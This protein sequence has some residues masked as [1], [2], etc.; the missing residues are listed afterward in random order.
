MYG[1]SAQAPGGMWRRPTTCWPC[2]VRN[3]TEP[4]RESLRPTKGGPFTGI[5]ATLHKNCVMH[6]HHVAN[7][8]FPQPDRLFE[9]AAA[10]NAAVDLFNAH[11][12]P[13]EC[14]IAGLVGLR[15]GFSTRL[16]HRW[17][18]LHAIPRAGLKA[19]VLQQATTYR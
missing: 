9:H 3:T 8:C 1:S 6:P 2:A 18:D 13:G 5:G 14:P 7:A 4:L 15:Q 19:H 12:S 17:H 10:L 16:L 11:P